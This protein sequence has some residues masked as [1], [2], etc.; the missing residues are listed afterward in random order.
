MADV[1]T[2][3]QAYNHMEAMRK[4]PR[5]LMAGTS[6]MRDAAREY[7]PQEPAETNAAWQSRLKRTVLINAFAQLV[8]SAVGKVFSRPPTVIDAPPEMLDWIEDLDGQGRHMTAVSRDAFRDGVVDGLSAF[9]V[10][11][12]RAPEGRT[13]VTQRDLRDNAVRPY[14]VLLRG[15]QII[16]TRYEWIQNRVTLTRV[17][18]REDRMEPDPNDV[19][20]ERFV[21]RVR[22]LTPGRSEVHEKRDG[23]WVVLDDET[24]ETGLDFIP[25]APFYAEF[26]EPGVANPPLRDVADLCLRLWQSVSDQVTLLKT[27]RVPMLHVAREASTEDTKGAR[28]ITLSANS[29]FVTGPNDRVAFVEHSG[30]AIGAGRQDILDLLQAIDRMGMMLTARETSADITATE[31]SLQATQAHSILTSMAQSFQDALEL[32][33]K[34]MCQ[35]RKLDAE[36]SVLVQKDFSQSLGGTSDITPLIQLQTAGI[37]SKEQVLVEAKRRGFLEESMDIQASLRDAADELEASQTIGLSREFPGLTPESETDT[38]IAPAA[39]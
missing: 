13:I 10:D 11:M 31:T 22:V 30:A 27:A 3:T 32:T 17:R 29:V 19:W 15:Q 1:S 24:V 38:G 4:L 37:L 8:N 21:E 16:E 23:R 28:K 18:L 6:A 36:P 35:M 9:L 7:L 25:F 34:Y 5:A 14:V 33:L 2:P 39:A 12:T 26:V 20:A